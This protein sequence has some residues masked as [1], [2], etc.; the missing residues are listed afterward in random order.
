MVWKWRE[1]Q[2][3]L[4]IVL[5]SK[6]TIDK[7]IGLEIGVDDYVTKP[8]NRISAGKCLVV[9]FW[10]WHDP[11]LEMR[12]WYERY[13]WSSHSSRCLLGSK[14]QQ[15]IGLDPSRIWIAHHLCD[16]CRS[17]DDSVNTFW[18]GVGLRITLVMFGQWTMACCYV[19]EHGHQDVQN[20]S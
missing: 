15:R 11:Q 19:N 4:I 6:D 2:Q 5:P 1:D 18:D 17:S 20:I 7:V 16:P 9:S 14:R 13:W 12:A 3:C 8:F 10:V